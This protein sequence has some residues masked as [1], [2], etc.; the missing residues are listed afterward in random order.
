MVYLLKRN[1]DDALEL[2]ADLLLTKGLPLE[3]R[4]FYL[5][6]ILDV[7]QA[8]NSKRLSTSFTAT[9]LG[10]SLYKKDLLQR[11]FYFVLNYT[12][13][14]YA[15]RTLAAIAALVLSILF[16]LS[17]SFIIQCYSEPPDTPGIT[18]FTIAPDNAYLIDKHDGSYSLYVNGVYQLT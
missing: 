10:F 11:R 18:Y 15:P 7:A 3:E 9:S 12:Q 8:E 1:L 4:R 13:Q 6:T 14:K 5:N 2:K 16:I 17:Y